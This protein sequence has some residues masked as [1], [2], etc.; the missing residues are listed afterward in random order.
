MGN[1]ESDLNDDDI[2]DDQYLDH[3]M[4]KMETESFKTDENYGDVKILRHTQ[5]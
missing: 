2:Q 1:S 5:S 4:D 3:K